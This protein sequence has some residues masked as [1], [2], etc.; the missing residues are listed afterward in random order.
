MAA[1]AQMPCCQKRKESKNGLFLNIV[2]L[3]DLLPLCRC[4]SGTL[5]KLFPLELLEQLVTRHLEP[6]LYCISMI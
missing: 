5:R 2:T 3:W 1:K 6:I 4:S